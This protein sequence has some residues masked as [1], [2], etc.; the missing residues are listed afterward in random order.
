[1]Y[2]C[3]C[4]F[5]VPTKCKIIFFCPTFLQIVRDLSPVFKFLD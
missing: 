5:Y 3:V 4:Y 1:M 2:V